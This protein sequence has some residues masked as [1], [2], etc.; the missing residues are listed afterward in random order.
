[1]RVGFWSLGCQSASHD[2]GG[3][4]VHEEAI[5]RTMMRVGFWSLGSQKYHY[6]GGF[7]SLWSQSGGP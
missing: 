5:R 4:L 2:E 7:L 1:M 3:V 6:E